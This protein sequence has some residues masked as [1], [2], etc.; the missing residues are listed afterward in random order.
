MKTNS[1]KAHHP[2]SKSFFLATFFITIALAV[3]P[4]ARAAKAG[5]LDSTFGTS[6]KV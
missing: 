1:T 4:E 5:T 3:H 2:Q 6:G